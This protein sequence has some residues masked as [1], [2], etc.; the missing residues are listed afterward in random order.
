MKK[1]IAAILLL[2]CMVIGSVGTPAQV[3]AA[4]VA[5]TA[6]EAEIEQTSEETSADTDAAEDTETAG[7]TKTA[8]STETAESTELAET[9]ESTELAE[10]AEST[11]LAE[12]VKAAAVNTTESGTE[13]AAEELVH[14]TGLMDLNVINVGTIAE[15]DVLD[16][17]E[18]NS[19]KSS[20]VYAAEWDSYSSNYVYNMLSTEEREFWDGLDASCRQVLLG[21]DNLTAGRIPYVSCGS[22]NS[23]R[24][25]YVAYM[26]RY[27]N[28]QYYFINVS[29]YKGSSSSGWRAAFGVYSAFQNGTARSTATQS[30]KNQVDTWK[31]TVN[32]LGSEAEKVKMIHDLIVEKVDYNYDISNRSS[33]NEDT[34]YTQSVYSVFCMDKTVCAGYA[35]AFEMMCNGVGVDCIAVTSDDH[36]WNKVRINDSWY[37]VDCTWADQSTIDYEYFE[38]SD[39]VYDADLANYASSH[40]EESYWSEYL[41][42]CTLDS[43]A[44]SS[45]PGTL[46][47]ITQ[48]TAQPQISV[49]AN[50]NVNYV[51]ITSSTPNAIIYYT[52]NGDT[53]T[54][55]YTRSEKY[56]STFTLGGSCTVK[57]VAV[58]DTYWDSN[59]ASKSVTATTGTTDTPDTTDTTTQHKSAP[60]VKLLYQYVLDRTAT[61]S[62]IDYWV[63]RLENGST[64][65]EVAYGFIFSQEFQNKNYS[66]ADYVEHLYLSLMGRASD[67]DGKADWVTHLKNGVS[68]LYVFRQ[69]TDS[70]EFGNLCNT[71]E[72]QRGTVT[73][74]ENRDQNYNVTRFVAR[75]YTEFLGR[76]Y[77]VDGLNDWSGRINSG[78]GMGNVAY[79]FVFSQ[80]C[81]NMNLSNSDYVKM[82]Y[83]GIFGREYDE[84]GLNDWVNQM[85]NGTSRE[86][87][88]WGFANS[89]E[90]ANMVASYGL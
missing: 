3:S 40:A 14:P 4:E 45:D 19:S 41:P 80:E 32:S 30:V 76:N 83:R 9:A 74:N 79:G 33:F 17:T 66:D 13:A 46:P 22:L 28:P 86:T 56:S 1:Q 38:R 65:A 77:D 37:N 12:S 48:Q 84:A 68:R 69:F 16:E 71:Y 72:I 61:Q 52:T 75:N 64:G 70:A 34:A 36:E 23:S 49:T 2:G 44:T 27:M 47:T 51:T 11:E 39:A 63:G 31:N 6:T 7:N 57:A 25:E 54:P 60:F 5:E 59:V 85:N 58:C 81:I 42:A 35:Q 73:L 55:A 18:V 50:N 62:E 10:T 21:T 43:G 78:Y 87:V 15:D 26:F 89:Q 29:L 88:F 67:A 90:F 82:L 24:I 8:G 20:S 53:P